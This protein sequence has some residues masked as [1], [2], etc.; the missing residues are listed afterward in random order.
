[1]GDEGQ[2]FEARRRGRQGGRGEEA[3]G[4][5]VGWGWGGCEGV[6]E[7]LYGGRGV[8]DRGDGRVAS[9]ASRRGQEYGLFPPL[10]SLAR[11]LTPSTAN[12]ADLTHLHLSETRLTLSLSLT[13]TPPP[14]LLPRLKHLHLR[15]TIFTSTSLPLLLHP[16]TVPSLR[17]LEYLSVHQSLVGSGMMPPSNPAG[18][19]VGAGGGLAA[20]TASFSALGGGAEGGGGHA[21]FLPL[22]P[23]LTHLALGS[24]VSKTLNLGDVLACEGLQT[25]DVPISWWL[26]T[27]A[28]EGGE[29]GEWPIGLRAIRFRAGGGEGGGRVD[30]VI[31]EEEREE[32]VQRA[33]MGALEVFDRCSAAGSAAGEATGKVIITLPR[34]LGSTA[35]ERSVITRSSSTASGEALEVHVWRGGPLDG[36]LAPGEDAEGA[37]RRNRD[38]PFDVGFGLWRAAVGRELGLGEGW[39]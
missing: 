27:G 10:S 30:G 2:E 16:L 13:S 17:V 23:Q 9:G 34:A 6:T 31:E 25:F 35:L 21:F 3:D 33:L 29:R 5:L 14:L 4:R 11:S 24:Y 26:A 7:G 39:E 20:L 15:S 8:V 12:R 28:G 38:G 18:A 1:M 19:G 22:A 36:D 37:E 32:Q